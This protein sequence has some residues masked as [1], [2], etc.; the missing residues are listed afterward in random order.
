MRLIKRS[1]DRE[2]YQ[3]KNPQKGVTVYGNGMIV[4]S[5]S[6]CA[7]SVGGQIESVPS[8]FLGFLPDLQVAEQWL[9]EPF[10]ED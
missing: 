6:G 9:D 3:G 7:V 1:N 2:V 8:M 10:R 4:A 5:R